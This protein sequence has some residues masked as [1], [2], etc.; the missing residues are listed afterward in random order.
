MSVCVVITTHYAGNQHNVDGRKY[1]WRVLLPVT[2]ASGAGCQ[3][4]LDNA[5]IPCPTA[6]ARTTGPLMSNEEISE[7]PL[8][9][10][11]TRPT[12]RQL[13]YKTVT[14]I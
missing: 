8:A 4:I 11:V 10:M 7:S 13:P 14:E 3:R 12:S 6:L 5:P 1:G 2:S 9:E